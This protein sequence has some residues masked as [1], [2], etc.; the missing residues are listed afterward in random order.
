MFAQID[1]FLEKKRCEMQSSNILITIT[2][3]AVTK[4]WARVD[5]AEATAG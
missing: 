2:T 1:S 5:L 3:T 4:A